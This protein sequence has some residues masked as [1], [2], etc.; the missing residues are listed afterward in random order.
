MA[1]PRYLP[2]VVAEL[3]AAIPPNDPNREDFELRS[4]KIIN[5]VMYS[6]PEALPTRWRE[7]AEVLACL[8]PDG[9]VANVLRSIFSG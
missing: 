2:D 4:G 3:L 5:S 9:S 8:Y 7:L 1:S 6:S